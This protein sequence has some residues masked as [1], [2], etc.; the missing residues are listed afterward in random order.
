VLTSNT[1]LGAQKA[2]H[3]LGEVGCDQIADTQPALVVESRPKAVGGFDGSADDFIE[4][5][6]QLIYLRDIEKQML[7]YVA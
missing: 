3:W 6:W 1:K 4:G 5:A 7:A 2:I